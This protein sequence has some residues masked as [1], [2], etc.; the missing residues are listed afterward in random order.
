MIAALVCTP[1]VFAH[2]RGR[3]ARHANSPDVQ[4]A[5]QKLRDTGFDPG[6]IDGKCGPQTRAALKNNFQR[7]KNLD[8]TGRLD[9][10][11]VSALGVEHEGATSGTR[12]GESG[13]KMD[14][15]SR[16]IPERMAPGT[17]SAPGAE[18]QGRD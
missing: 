9:A 1:P 6:S 3:A 11:T 15:G 7:S 17:P 12:G 8:V 18:D 4:Q 16:R 10:R 5:Q 13:R 2:G 14:E